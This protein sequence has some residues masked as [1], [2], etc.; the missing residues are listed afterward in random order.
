MKER[1]MKK[2]RKG[3]LSAILLITMLL[4]SILPAALAEDSED[5]VDWSEWDFGLGEEQEDGKAFF[6][7]LEGGL[8]WIGPE[9]EES[10][11][12]DAL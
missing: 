6:Y 8:F 3:L 5:E 2:G 1:N 12:A 7:T 10:D 4:T 11:Q 9:A